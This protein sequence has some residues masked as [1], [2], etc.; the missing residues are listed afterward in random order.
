MKLTR[1]EAF[2][3]A[4][5]VATATSLTGCNPLANRAYAL[6]SEP[7]T[8]P[9]AEDDLHVAVLNRFGF[10]PSTHSLAVIRDQG[11]DEWF[12]NQL[13]PN[14]SEPDHLQFRLERLEIN[15]LGPWDLRD[16]PM[17]AIISQLQQATIL[18]AVYSDWQ[19]RERMADFWSNHFNIF[20][21]KGLSAYRRPHDD[22]EV[23]R[24]H[25]LGKFPEMLMASA[26]STAMLIYLDQQN[27]NAAHPNENYARELLELHSLG[28]D[29]GYTQA[30]V[31]EV[32]RCFTGWSEER[33][34][35]KKKGAFL[36]RADL[37]D[38]KEK[39]VL[40]DVIPA[41]G[42]VEDG[43]RVVSMVA[44]HP[45]TAKH[46]SRKLCTY[47]LGNP[48]EEIQKRVAS[49]FLATEGDIPSM[50]KIIFGEFKS[51]RTKV[52]KRPLDFLVSSLRAL[53]A[54]TDASD[55]IRKSLEAMG[56]PL[57]LWPMPDGFPVDTAAWTS[58]LLARWN[59]ASE[60]AS[61][62]LKGTT[63]DAKKLTSELPSDQ[64][65]QA[66]F[67][68]SNNAPTIQSLASATP[69]REL[70]DQ[71]ALAIASPEFQWR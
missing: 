11:V 9:T 62:G 42:G 67:R 13:Q 36:F 69:K 57:N 39:K 2:A 17:E 45:S 29:G 40:G 21:K 56:Q 46:V 30:D 7:I 52:V 6:T 32:A 19:L 31:M 4:A 68:I 25:A 53:D 48:T 5:G 38:S 61:N 16:W 10:G 70:T 15:H 12:N 14:E 47:F 20:S 18:K 27:S 43:E 37:H 41:G 50:M 71:I 66:I 55:P 44:R 23:I 59:F 33:G 1:R 35:L 28:V 58:S 64:G 24:K 8:P 49:E 26:K 63:I 65:L 60:V 51:T 34:F 3:L 54:A 22:R